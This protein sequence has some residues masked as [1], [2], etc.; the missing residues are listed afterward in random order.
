MIKKLKQ[1][2]DKVKALLIKS[3]ELRDNDNRLIANY[4]YHEANSNLLKTSAL[5]FL[6]EFA[7]GKYTNPETIRRC[8][9][10]LQEE[11]PELRGKLWQEKQCAAN[12]VK[13]EVHS[14]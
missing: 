5:D 13:K 3:P 1:A 9:Q 8:R 10:R 4:Y 11:C 14:L 12:E 7:E 6:H 2:K